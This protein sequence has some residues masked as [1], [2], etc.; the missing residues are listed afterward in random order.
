[1]KYFTSDTYFGNDSKCILK[2]EMRDFVSPKDYTK[3]Q[4]KQW[5]DKLNEND[6]LYHLGDFC[7]Y[8]LVEHEWLENGLWAVRDIKAHV[9]LITGENEERII[10]DVFKG[11]FEVFKRYCVQLGFEDVHRSIETQINGEWYHL[12]HVPSYDKKRCLF[13]HL[14][15]FYGL[16]TKNGIN[17][18]TDLHNFRA[19]S[20]DDITYLQSEKSIIMPEPKPNAY[21]IAQFC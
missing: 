8:N 1:M 7:N 2:Q 3:Y 6:I 14:R 18:C 4:I 16:Y 13:G 11:D 9:V 19:L 10:G 5:N 21:R 15:K 17:V 12:A 20:E